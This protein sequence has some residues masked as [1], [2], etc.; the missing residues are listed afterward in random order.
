MA[1]FSDSASACDALGFYLKEDA[2]SEEGKLKLPIEP[3]DPSVED[4]LYEICCKAVEGAG[5]Y[6]VN[7]PADHTTIVIAGSH[8]YEIAITK[9]R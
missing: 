9:R 3:G 2:M 6:L 4:Q 8:Q 5:G 1:W 7:H